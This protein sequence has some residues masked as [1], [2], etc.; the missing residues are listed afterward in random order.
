MPNYALN[1]VCIKGNVETI[2][3]LY[4]NAKQEDDNFHLLNTMVPRPESE[5]H[6]WHKWNIN[7]WGTKWDI[8]DPNLEYSDN[9]DGTA[10]IT[11]YFLT[12]WSEP[13]DAY[14]TFQ[15]QNNDVSI[16]AM[17][18]ELGNGYL[19][20]YINGIH[21]Y[22]EVFSRNDIENVPQEIIEPFKEDI[23]DYLSMFDEDEEEV[24]DE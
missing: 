1:Y 9:G 10:K 6:N 15:E 23:E 2:K 18:M 3:S 13:V 7:N 20:S 8:S 19:G 11:G 22:Y 5:N 24:C 12:P 14:Q 16:V 17:A 4:E 21:Q